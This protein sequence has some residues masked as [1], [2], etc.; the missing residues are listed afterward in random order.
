M[1]VRAWNA[2]GLYRMLNR[3]L[4]LAADPV[5][6]YRVLQHFYRLDNALVGRFYAARSTWGDWARILTGTPPIPVPRALR[7]LIMYKG[8][9]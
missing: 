1:S 7:A 4:F 6:R 3:M 9:A 2:R 5:E 8:N